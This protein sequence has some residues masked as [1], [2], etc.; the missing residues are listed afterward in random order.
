MEFLAENYLYVALGSLAVIIIL[1][2]IIVMS[3]KKSKKREKE[4]TVNIGEIKTGSIDDVASNMKKEENNPAM[5]P[6]NIG[7]MT[8]SIPVV[9]ETNAAPIP[10]PVN[11]PAPIVDSAKVE[12]DTTEESAPVAEP[13]KVAAG[14]VEEPVKVAEEP[15][16]T[17]T[18]VE[19]TPVEPVKEPTPAVEPTP[20][21]SPMSEPVAA[22]E[23]KPAE[24]PAPAE[25]VQP[26]VEPQQ[27]PNIPVIEPAV[28]TN[29][30]EKK[31]DLEVF[32][33]EADK[34]KGTAVSGF[35]S[36]NVEK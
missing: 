25:P 9:N 4:E 27:E 10:E 12:A 15:V 7:E 22:E 23:P 17:P 6:Q 34:P 36:V 5:Q 16:A 1:I 2:M 13:T 28:S 21:E 19:P 30:E 18:T 14:S 11:E 20:V 26:M 32:G 8:Q 33:V 3:N 35:S 24:Q 31:E 29:P